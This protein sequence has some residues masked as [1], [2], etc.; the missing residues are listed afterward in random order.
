MHKGACQSPLNNWLFYPPINTVTQ[1]NTIVPPWAQ[2]S[3]ILAAGLPPIIT[4]AEP[5]TIVSGGP[6]QVHVSPT[7][8]AG[9]APIN[10]VG[11]QGPAT[12]PP[13]W[14]MGTG[15]GVNIGHT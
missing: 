5:V 4:V 3:P 2:L 10:T 8:A 7:T 15:P 12:G 14:G 1:P 13:T 11:T 9:N 6:T